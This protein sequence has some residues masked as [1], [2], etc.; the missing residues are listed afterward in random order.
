MDD[1]YHDLCRSHSYCARGT[2]YYAAACAV[3]QELWERAKDVSFPDD[4]MAAFDALSEWIA[5]FRKNSRKRPPGQD[6]FYSPREKSDFQDL[7]ALHANLRECRR[8]EEESST[9]LDL[10][11]SMIAAT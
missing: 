6:Y 5:G 7:F 3:C 8:I 10:Q 9:S 11:V 2:Q 4:A 1:P